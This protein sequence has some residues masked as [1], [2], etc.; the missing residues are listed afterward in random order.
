[1][2]CFWGFLG[3]LSASPFEAGS[4]PALLGGSASA[5]GSSSAHK[6]LLWRYIR[7]LSAFSNSSM[8]HVASDNL[9][10]EC[11]SYIF[12][13]SIQCRCMRARGECADLLSVCQHQCFCLRRPLGHL[14]AAC[15][16]LGWSF[17]RMQLRAA[18]GAQRTGGGC[19]A[20]Q[21]CCLPGWQLP[22]SCSHSPAAGLQG[23]RSTCK[24]NIG[25]AAGC[26]SLP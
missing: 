11:H 10:Y 7:E 18:A 24:C 8:P 25:L 19:R 13:F 17:G 15:W 23:L 21:R 5:F 6:T 22:R 3:S 4:L 14:Q 12:M 1:M 26:L 16:A 2:L 20:S 9:A